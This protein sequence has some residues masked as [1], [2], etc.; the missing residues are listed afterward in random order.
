MRTKPVATRM[1][2][3]HHHSL[4]RE[5]LLALGLVVGPPVRDL[6][7]VLGDPGTGV[8]P[9]LAPRERGPPALHPELVVHPARRLAPVVVT[10]ADGFRLEALHVQDV[11]E[12]IKGEAAE[13]DATSGMLAIEVMPGTGPESPLEEGE[14]PC[15]GRIPYSSKSHCT[16]ESSCS[17]SMGF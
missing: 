2:G 12:L 10:L 6:E 3:I 15:V 11:Q 9:A 8:L 4:R 5:P 16:M 7:P 14:G 13:I 17:M 1:L